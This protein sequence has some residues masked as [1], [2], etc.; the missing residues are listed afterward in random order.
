[1]QFYFDQSKE[2]DTYS[3]PDGE[4]FQLTAEEAMPFMD[5]DAI[6]Q[7]LKDFPLAN[8]NSRARG[9]MIDA[10]VA[11]G[12]LTGGWFAHACFPGCLPDS[13]P[14]GPYETYQEAID[15]ARELFM[16]D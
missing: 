13:D 6:H 4:A 14:V 15:A 8:M 11:D 16:G 2:K 3:L 9:K 7:Y 1:M 10:M 5:E 12:A